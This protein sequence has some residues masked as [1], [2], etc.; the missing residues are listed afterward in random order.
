M[1]GLAPIKALL[2]R[3][4]ISPTALSCHCKKF[5]SQCR[6]RKRDKWGREGLSQEHMGFPQGPGPQGGGGGHLFLL[7]SYKASMKGLLFLRNFL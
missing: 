1:N 6:C 2:P 3:G 7:C 4:L 5:H